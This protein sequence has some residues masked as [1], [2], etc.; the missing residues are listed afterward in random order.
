MRSVKHHIKGVIG[1]A[2]LN[3]EEFNT[4]LVMIEQVLNSRP[5]SPIST[6]PNDT[7]P[8]FLNWSTLRI[9]RKIFGFGPNK[10][11]GSI[12]AAATLPPRQLET[13]AVRVF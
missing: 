8:L 11:I 6:D 7:L 12:S 9:A 5:I 4:I 3:F 10:Q 13:L 1:N 2:I